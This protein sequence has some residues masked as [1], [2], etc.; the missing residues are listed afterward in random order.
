MFMLDRADADPAAVQQAQTLLDALPVTAKCFI[1]FFKKNG[2][3]RL[4]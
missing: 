1:I 2:I 4:F 3:F